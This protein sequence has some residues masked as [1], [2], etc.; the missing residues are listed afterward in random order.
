[1]KVCH[2]QKHSALSDFI[3]QVSASASTFRWCAAE[4]LMWQI[5]AVVCHHAKDVR[6]KE[7]PQDF[8]ITSYQTCPFLDLISQSSRDAFLLRVLRGPSAIMKDE[9]ASEGLGQTHKVGKRKVSCGCPRQS[10]LHLSTAL[11]CETQLRKLNPLCGFERSPLRW[12][13]WT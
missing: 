9:P 12:V 13:R 3:V 8:F 10:I 11:I 4:G 2:P 7:R 6:L 5:T 1:M